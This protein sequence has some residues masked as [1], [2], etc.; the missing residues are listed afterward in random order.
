MAQQYYVVSSAGRDRTRLVAAR[1]W[2][3]RLVGL[4]LPY[5]PPGVSVT[6]LVRY[7]GEETQHRQICW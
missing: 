4:A 3:A 6:T 1:E 7:V 5:V 2:G